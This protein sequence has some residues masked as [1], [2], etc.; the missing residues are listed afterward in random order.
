MMLLCALLLVLR[1][2]LV[3]QAAWTYSLK[4]YHCSIINSFECRRVTICDYE[5][6]RCLTVSIRVSP[7]ELHVYKNC[8][9]NCTFVYEAQMPPRAPYHL[10]R[11]NSFY[12]VLCCNGNH[13]NQGGPNNV[14]RD[15]LPDEAIEEAI[16][17][18][19]RLGVSGFFLS[20]ACILVSRTLT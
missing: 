18:A 10:L 1:S 14:E 15:I 6:R 12:F 11:T 20:F 4:C 8:T 19:L 17:R 13:C 9:D 3:A 2:A 5:V 16:D 7:R